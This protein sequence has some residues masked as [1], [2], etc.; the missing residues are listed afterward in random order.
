[1]NRN[2]KKRLMK[3]IFCL[4]C[5]GT[6]CF[7]LP[8]SAMA[9]S[10]P[11]DVLLVAEADE[12]TDVPALSDVPAATQDDADAAGQVQEEENQPDSN[13]KRGI[14]LAV[15]LIIS[16]LGGRASYNKVTRQNKKD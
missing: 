3:M 1:M 15:F 9:A 4:F 13:T 7:L 16:Y 14:I 6:F 2:A 5:L 10:V 11:Q 12:E 8:V